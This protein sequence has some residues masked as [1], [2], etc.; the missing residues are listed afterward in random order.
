M[1]YQVAYEIV[2]ETLQDNLEKLLERFEHLKT[3]MNHQG[4]SISLGLSFTYEGLLIQTLYFQVLE[5][6]EPLEHVLTIFK[7]CQHSNLEVVSELIQKGKN[8]T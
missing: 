5:K 8:I 1:A 6:M 4:I 3:K 7:I 2:K